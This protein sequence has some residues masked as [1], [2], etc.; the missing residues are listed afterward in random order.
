MTREW[1]RATLR[2]G[3]SR[4][5]A[6]A[7][8]VCLVRPARASDAR[9]ERAFVRCA[10]L[11]RAEVT[12]DSAWV[13]WKR[14]ASFAQLCWQTKL[15]RPLDSG[16]N[17]RSGPATARQNPPSGSRILHRFQGSHVGGWEALQ[18]FALGRF[19]EVNAGFIPRAP[20]IVNA[21]PLRRLSKRN[22]GAAMAIACTGQ[23]STAGQHGVQV[24]ALR[25]PFR[26]SGQR[27]FARCETEP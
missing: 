10:P 3:A 14:V 21:P 1:H 27:A 20:T 17:R 2:P 25:L 13:F 18:L 22:L 9:P 4:R 12:R 24:S 15:A 19:N 8:H 11:V 16:R 23:R 26:R 5:R 6:A 7:A